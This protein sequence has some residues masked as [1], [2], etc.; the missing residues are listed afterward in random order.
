MTDI[1][2]CLSE[3][4]IKKGD[5]G[6]LKEIDLHRQ[7]PKKSAKNDPFAMSKSERMKLF[8]GIDQEEAHDE[9]WAE[10][11]LKW[12]IGTV[13]RTESVVERE[14]GTT[15]AFLSSEKFDKWRFGCA[16]GAKTHLAIHGLEHASFYIKTKFSCSTTG[17]SQGSLL[18]SQVGQ[19]EESTGRN[20]YLTFTVLYGEIR[21][22]TDED[23]TTFKAGESFD[24][25]PN[26]EF[27]Q[28]RHSRRGTKPTELEW[29]RMA[30]RD[31]SAATASEMSLFENS[32]M[33]D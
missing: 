6:F 3:A 8:G 7:M 13:A 19:M 24:I 21:L 2:P 31:F 33:G 16:P 4:Q 28:L 22:V 11:K 15:Y 18:F 10:A 32:T 17:F 25:Q 12:E 27:Y 9:I 14:D 26:T 23:K 30:G 20:E 29:E 5:F 1:Q